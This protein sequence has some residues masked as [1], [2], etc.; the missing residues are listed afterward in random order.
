[1]ARS[2][3]SH[4]GDEAAFYTFLRTSI[5]TQRKSRTRMANEGPKNKRID[6]E[7]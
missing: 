3:R 2:D 1:M 7:K 6:A 4:V 5:N